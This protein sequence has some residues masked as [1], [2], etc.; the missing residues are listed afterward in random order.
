MSVFDGKRM[1]CER[2]GARLY[3]HEQRQRWCRVCASALG[4][5]RICDRGRTRV[6]AAEID[7]ARWLLAEAIR[8]GN[9]TDVVEAWQR[10]IATA[11]ATP[12]GER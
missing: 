11:V 10:W 12:G 6:S 5:E 8:C 3:Y 4:I 1:P 9:R 7:A 2:C